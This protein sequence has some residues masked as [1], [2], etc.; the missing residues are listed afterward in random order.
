MAKAMGRK[1]RGGVRE[2]N[3]RLQRP[4]KEERE[5]ARLRREAG[6][7][8][9]VL[10]QP[11]RRGNYD[12][13]CA[14]PLGR[15]VLDAGLRRELYDAGEEYAETVRRWRAIKGVPVGL[16][17]VGAGTGGDIADET[18]RRLCARLQAMRQAVTSDGGPAALCALDRVALD[19]ET[20]PGAIGFRV[21][22][23]LMT[24]AEHLG[25][26]ARNTHP[27]RQSRT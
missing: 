27:Y 17:A 4:S 18:V 21:T 25:L 12:Q 20:L 23:A 6:E 3:G 22:G 7:R 8:A 16:Q 5:A 13:L 1:R 26:V 15:H 14:S 9:T 10:A 11:H 19:H 2:P 24:L